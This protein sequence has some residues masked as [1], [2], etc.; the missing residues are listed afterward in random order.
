MSHF[1]AKMYTLNNIILIFLATVIK[2]PDFP[3]LLKTP[4]LSLT[5]P[6]QRNHGND[7]PTATPCN[8]TAL[9]KPSIWAKFDSASVA[10]PGNVMARQTDSVQLEFDQYVAQALISCSSCPMHWWAQRKP[11]YPILS[12][13]AQTMLCVPD[14]QQ[15]LSPAS[16]L[17]SKPAT[18]HVQKKYAATV[19]SWHYHFSDGQSVTVASLLGR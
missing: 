14:C 4:R 11:S 12:S 1:K 10:T 7:S 13:V 3:W 19:K 9:S 6:D 18:Y 16:T 17:F 5:S 15:H 8:S 2:F